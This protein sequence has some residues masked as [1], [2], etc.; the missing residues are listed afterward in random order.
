MYFLYMLVFTIS[1]HGAFHKGG[2]N[3]EK[4]SHFL[5]FSSVVISCTAAC[6]CSLFDF[7]REN[8]Q[9]NKIGA[10]QINFFQYDTV[11]DPGSFISL[12]E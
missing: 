6:F 2:Y 12:Q 9:L 5:A 11:S 7:I 3:I 1:Y 10:A 4:F 8:I